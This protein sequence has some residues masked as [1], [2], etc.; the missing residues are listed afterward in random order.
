MCGFCT[1]WMCEAYVILW[2]GY[3]GYCNGVV[4]LNFYNCIVWFCIFL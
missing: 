2:W 3:G 4:V 1:V